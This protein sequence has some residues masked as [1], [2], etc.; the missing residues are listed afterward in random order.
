LRLFKPGSRP[1][2]HGSP[3]GV[4]DDNI[5][6]NACEST[7]LVLPLQPQVHVKKTDHFWLKDDVYSLSDMF[8]AVKY[9]KQHLAKHFEGGTVYQAFLS[10]LFYHRWHSPISGVIEE[11]Y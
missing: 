9:N 10:A 2:G 11:I 3:V 6:I 8:G 5:V 7:P 1:I 4:L